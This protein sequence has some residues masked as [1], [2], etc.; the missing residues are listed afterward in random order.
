ME[1]TMQRRIDELGRVVLP[2]E[3]RKLLS[4]KEK[5]TLNIRC[6]DGKITMERAADCC[7]LC[8]TG[9]G[10]LTN[11]EGGLLCPACIERV[12]AL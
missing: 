4:L 2:M 8:H 11:M 1:M 5:D 6:S 7:A 3:M 9:D 10:P 12:K